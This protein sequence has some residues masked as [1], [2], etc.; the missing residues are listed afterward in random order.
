[1]WIEQTPNGKFKACERYTDPLTGKTK[2][3]TTTIEKDTKSQRKA[4]ESVLKAKIEK[5][6]MA[7]QDSEYTLQE[8]ADKFIQH[9]KSAVRKSTASRDE[10]MVNKVVS[11]I[12]K[13]SIASKLTARF[14][15]E[16]LR[17]TEKDNVGLNTYLSHL[18]RMLKW[19]YRMEY[20]DDISFLSRLPAYP[21]PG[22]K[23]R[24]EDKYMS[25][26]ELSN[27]LEAMTVR[28]WK[29]LTKFLA[30]SG[31]R[32]GEAMA[33][34]DADVG[35]SIIVN[36]TY[37]PHGRYLTSSPKTEAGNREVFVQVELA[38][39]IKDIRAYIRKE[40][41]EVGYRSDLFIPGKDGEP[42]QYYSYKKY[43]QE[44]TLKVIGRALTPHALRHTHVSLLAEAGVQLDAISRRV[45]HDDSKVTKEIY[46]H[47]TEK[48][49][50]KD[51]EQIRNI[52]IL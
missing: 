34:K 48:Q 17:S 18:K 8:L 25:S 50:E 40:S 21:D 31:L 47:I 24:I 19:A 35:A 14:I 30:L 44:N 38:E 52:K 16:K 36:K 11:V 10:I 6:T 2:K 3:V 39:V 26:E 33:L 42:F 29:L 22:K 7:K 4:A 43:L 46:L 23:L 32:I 13:D 27:V 9:Q 1:M 20:I 41:F 5:L 12:G 51:N 37:N 15:D 45:G 28:K 49:K